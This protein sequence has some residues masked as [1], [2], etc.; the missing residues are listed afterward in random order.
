[1]NRQ[2]ERFGERLPLS[3]GIGNFFGTESHVGSPCRFGD[4]LEE[5]LWV[6]DC[7]HNGH[8][9]WR[10][11]FGCV[12]SIQIKSGVRLPVRIATWHPHNA[13]LNRSRWMATWISLSLSLFCA[14]SHECDECRWMAFTCQKIEASAFL[15]FLETSQLLVLK[16]GFCRGETVVVERVD[17]RD[18]GRRDAGWRTAGRKGTLKRAFFKLKKVWPILPC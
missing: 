11:W 10:A 16:R 6:P 13:S 17:R 8:H 2:L 3:A 15:N 5:N 14:S 18:A 9:S 1:M 7:L 12:W 4:S